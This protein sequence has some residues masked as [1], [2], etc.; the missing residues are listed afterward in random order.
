MSILQTTSRASDPI[1]LSGFG[2]AYI[3]EQSIEE[4]VQ[5][6]LLPTSSIPGSRLV[7]FKEYLIEVS[8]C[9]CVRF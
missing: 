5:C 7:G 9:A 2:V 8:I 4:F 6:L 3:Y 1:R